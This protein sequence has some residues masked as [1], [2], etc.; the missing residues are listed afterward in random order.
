MH[1]LKSAFALAAAI[2]CIAS[3]AAA[4]EPITIVCGESAGQTYWLQS[5]DGWTKDGFAGG[6]VLLSRDSKG[7]WDVIYVTKLN[8]FSAKGDGAQVGLLHSVDPLLSG[9]AT[10]VAFYPLGTVEVFH[11]VGN[12]RSVEMATSVAKPMTATAPARSSL[13]VSKC[14]VR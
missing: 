13:F 4:A 14:T 7:E 2:S 6:N 12:G 5:K 11:L 10:I 9:S 8:K 3:L 1:C